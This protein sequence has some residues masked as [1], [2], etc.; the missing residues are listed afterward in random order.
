MTRIGYKEAVERLNEGYSIRLNTI[1]YTYRIVIDEVGTTDTEIGYLT[2][3]TFYKL[4]NTLQLEEYKIG[5]LY[6]YY[7]LA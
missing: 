4:N 1:D 6:N 7:R 3:D 2:Y 5:Y